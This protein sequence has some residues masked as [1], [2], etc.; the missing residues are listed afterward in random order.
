MARE[1]RGRKKGRK[2][3]TVQ[4]IVSNEQKK[5]RLYIYIDRDEMHEILYPESHVARD[6]SFHS[7]HLI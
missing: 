4:Q 2:G 7:F 5:I 6:L 1:I 3:E